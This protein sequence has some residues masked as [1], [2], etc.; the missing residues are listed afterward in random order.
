[1]FGHCAVQLQRFLTLSVLHT[2]LR[3]D[4]SLFQGDDTRCESSST[5]DQMLVGHKRVHTKL[6][7]RKQ[8][9]DHEL[10]A[11]TRMLYIIRRKCERCHANDA[12]DRK[13]WSR[14]RLVRQRRTSEGT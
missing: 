7:F 9:Q 8:P 14:S 11:S 13:G 10:P 4:R 1:M 5:L 6:L 2:I 3:Y 12:L